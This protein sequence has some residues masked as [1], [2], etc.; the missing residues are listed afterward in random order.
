MGGRKVRAEGRRAWRRDRRV[1]ALFWASIAALLF[2]IL[3]LGQP[4]EQ[5][6]LI[7]RNSARLHKAS[8]DIVLVGIDDRS[9]E[10]FQ[11][12]PWP[13]SLHAALADR[14]R[15]AGARRVFFDIDFSIPT[16][17]K[18]DRALADAFRRLGGRVTVPVHFVID[19]STGERTDSFPAP[20]LRPWV[21]L[22]SINTRYSAQGYVWGVPYAL[23]YKGVDR[24]S[25]AASLAG[26]HGPTGEMF[27]IDYAV[28]ARSVPVIG[29]RDV[30]NRSALARL[31]GKDVV[32]GATSPRLNDIHNLPGY[33]Q[34][35]GSYIQIMGAETLK[36]GR[37]VAVGWLPPLLFAF[38]AALCCIT[39]KR[40]DHLAG[41]F[42]ISLVVTLF[43]PIPLESAHISVGIFPS[44]VLL[45][46]ACGGMLWR[47]LRASYRE[48]GSINPVT[49]LPNLNALRNAA[50]PADAPLIAARVQ[51]Y[52]QI[53]AALQTDEERTLAEQISARLTVGS[54]TVT[55]YQG[56]EGIFAWFAPPQAE[57]EEHLGALHALFRSPLVVAENR[58]DLSVTFGVDTSLDR[59][60]PSRL[61]GAL[62]AADDAASESRRWKRYD[63]GEGEDAAWR[64]SILSQLDAAIGAGDL[65]VAYQ[66]KF[67]VKT[68]QAI[69]A[70]ALVRWTHPTKGP[71]S[72]MEFIPAAEQSGRIEKLTEFVLDR[73][74][75]AAS[76]AIQ[77]C[78]GFTMSVNLSPKLLGA[79]PLEAKVLDLLAR[80]G[81]PPHC[82][83]LEVTETAALARAEADLAPLH[84]LRARGVQISIDDY[85][86]GLSTLDYIKRLP[87]SEI[88]IDKSFVQA[89][90]KSHSDRLMVHSTI[91]LAH[92]LGHKVVAEGVEDL[93][94]FE[95]LAAMG[96]DIVQG[97]Y[98]A[99]PM[100]FNNLTPFI[101]GW[102]KSAA[103]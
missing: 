76:L 64:L 42:V 23:T 22:G 72:P 84:R 102:R 79:F 48:R 100:S 19:P 17:S 88:K 15:E 96:C 29:A 61:G 50:A 69:G 1:R 12:W 49:G 62:S 32:V 93:S 67:D 45:F 54:E 40:L 74:L 51:N 47:M 85:G 94:T 39:R 30:L 21:Q 59:P 89:V 46:G 83:T 92:S 52:A 27:P 68:R 25:F 41:G 86:T 11:Q 35:P 91:Q 65:W 28:D 5:D 55:V 103:A 33:G 24:P 73:A 43:A 56:D 31:R 8:G 98:F 36:A 6:L 81:V 14:L 13:R 57:L 71:I 3:D 97:F 99:K 44:L 66:P 70:E 75:R 9:L 53:C 87:A 80:Y 10:Q 4:L 37:P 26:V 63:P 77:R 38:V 58:F 18:E 16:E 95:T 60:L 78:P 20:I 34:M 90:G 101:P 2:G 82:L 7:A